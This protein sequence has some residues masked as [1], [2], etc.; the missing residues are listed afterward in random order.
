MK[1]SKEPALSGFL[2]AHE[3][4][5]GESRGGI[6]PPR[7]PRT[8]REPLDSYG[9]RCSAVGTHVQRPCL[10]HGLLPLPVGLWPRLNNAAPSVQLH[11][12]AFVPT[13]SCS[14]PV[15]RIGT[16]ILAV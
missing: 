16:L 9:S 14:V 8:V 10:A 3:S 4:E 6:S 7:A 13:T 5:N 2:A 1:V 12:R 11:Y 15:L